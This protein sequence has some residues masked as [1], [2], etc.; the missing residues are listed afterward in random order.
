MLGAGGV[1]CGVVAGA[2]RAASGLCSEVTSLGNA[3][4]SYA[5][6]NDYSP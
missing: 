3:R 6:V 4:A 5:R 1:G 2:L